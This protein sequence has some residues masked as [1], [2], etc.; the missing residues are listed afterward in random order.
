M[1]N[2]YSFVCQSGLI[3]I[4]SIILAASLR[5]H[6][7]NAEIIAA[8]PEQF[9]ELHPIT[10]TVFNNLNVK[11]IL[12][13]N[14]FNP[15]YAVGNKMF[16]Y[17]YDTDCDYKI[18]LD[19][20]V[21][22]LKDIEDDFNFNDGFF[23]SSPKY[24][25]ITNKEWKDAF[26]ICDVPYVYDFL[27]TRSALFCTKT[28]VNFSKTWLSVCEKI[29]YSNINLRKKRQIDQ[30]GLTIASQKLKNIKIEDWFNNNILRCP[31]DVYLF[32]DEKNIK[33]YSIPKFFVLQKGWLYLKKQNQD[34]YGSKNPNSL[35]F[36]S[37][38][39]SE[40]YSIL[41]KYPIID[42]HPMW[43]SLHKL[44]FSSERVDENWLNMMLLGI[45]GSFK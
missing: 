30:I 42:R 15:L 13:K 1:K 43:D 11:I 41:S 22:C 18:F 6:T 2:S 5:N 19:S 26:F 12:F 21:I 3:E 25:I 8:Y 28:S 10:K 9:G 38:I 34:Q 4:Q 45:E 33:K 40:I 35:V 16:A 7:K 24:D 20:D 27:M 23:I 17:N 36:Y 44:Y 14:N 31:T 37:E 39:R 32:D 29:Y